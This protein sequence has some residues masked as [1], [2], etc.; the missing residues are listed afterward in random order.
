MLGGMKNKG[1]D[2]MNFSMETCLIESIWTYAP[3]TSDILLAS[4]KGE[5]S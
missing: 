1:I 5:G 2:I 4:F 3:Y